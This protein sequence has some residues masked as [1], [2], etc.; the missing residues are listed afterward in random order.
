MNPQHLEEFARVF[1]QIPPQ[2][3]DDGVYITQDGGNTRLAAY[4][5][6]TLV[7]LCLTAFIAAAVIG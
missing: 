4:T 7:L 6:L 3:N 5:G 1:E 2:S